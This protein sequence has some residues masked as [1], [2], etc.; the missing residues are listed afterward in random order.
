MHFY[1]DI[2]DSYRSINDFNYFSSQRYKTINV[3]EWLESRDT[4]R[5]YL[6]KNGEANDHDG[7]IAYHGRRGASSQDDGMD[8]QGEAQKWGD[9]GLQAWRPW[10]VE[11]QVRCIVSIHRRAKQQKINARAQLAQD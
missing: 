11:G 9:Q 8:S 7:R 10:P 4:I 1:S 2:A 6:V 3:L 5:P